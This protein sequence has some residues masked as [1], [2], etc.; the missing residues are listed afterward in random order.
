[1]SSSAEHSPFSPGYA[2][3]EQ[4]QVVA[5]LEQPVHSYGAVDAAGY[6]N[7]YVHCCDTMTLNTWSA[8]V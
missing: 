3:V 7:G 5:L 1:M 8:I 6:Q 2:Y 4:V